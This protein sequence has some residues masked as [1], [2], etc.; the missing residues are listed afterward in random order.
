MNGVFRPY[1]RAGIRRP[2][3]GAGASPTPGR[4][5]MCDTCDALPDPAT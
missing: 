2:R 3:P 4:R 5:R 1:R